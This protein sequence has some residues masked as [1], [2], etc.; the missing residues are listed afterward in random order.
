MRPWAKARVPDSVPWTKSAAST[1]GAQELDCRSYSTVR[2]G[3][4]GAVAADGEGGRSAFQYGGSIRER[5]QEG[6][7]VEDCALGVGGIRQQAG[8][9]AVEIDQEVPVVFRVGVTGDGNGEVEAGLAGGEHD[10]APVLGWHVLVEHGQGPVD[11]VGHREVAGAQ[12]TKGEGGD[13]GVA[14]RLHRVE[15]GD[16]DGGLPV[17]GHRGR[18]ARGA[19]RNHFAPGD[20]SFAEPK[21]VKVFSRLST[22][23]REFSV[24]YLSPRES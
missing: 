9:R 10:A 23:R 20:S 11:L 3:Q 6:V 15:R 7:V 5:G 4:V 18:R 12:D 13:A 2:G 24:V 17:L 21:R 19:L 8:F 14:F 16:R 22:N 1:A